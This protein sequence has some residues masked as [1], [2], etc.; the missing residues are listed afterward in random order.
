M[1]MA[2]SWKARKRANTLVDGVK[3]IGVVDHGDKSV[4]RSIEDLN[5]QIRKDKRNLRSR[6]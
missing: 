3:D 6:R 5:R 2:G 1:P 4:S